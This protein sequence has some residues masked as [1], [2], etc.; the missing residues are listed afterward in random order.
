MTLGLAPQLA[1]HA[2]ADIELLASQRVMMHRRSEVE[3]GDE[4]RAAW[5]VN[6]ALLSI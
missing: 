4:S 3:R 6:A 5:R 1:G 2:L